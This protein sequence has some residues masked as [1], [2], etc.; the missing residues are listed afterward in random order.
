MKSSSFFSVFKLL[1]ASAFF[2]ISAS[3]VSA[4]TSLGKAEQDFLDQYPNAQMISPGVYSINNDGI[5]ETYAF[6]IGGMAHTLSKLEDL[7]LSN[8]EQ[9]SEEQLDAMEKARAAL[10]DAYYSEI[11]STATSKSGTGGT[12]TN[13]GTIC[14]GSISY[15]LTAT[16][17]FRTFFSVSASATAGFQQFSGSPAISGDALLYTFAKA[18]NS[19]ASIT[20]LEADL[21]TFSP[22]GSNFVSANQSSAIAGVSAQCLEAEAMAYIYIQNCDDFESVS[23]TY[24]LN[25]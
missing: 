17:E 5:E 24:Q 18:F 16:A 9:I 20:T 1:S 15:D 19:S 12:S 2:S 4:D 8:P 23:R 10:E 21:A 3:A 22:N 6:G 7:I 14:N 25:C 13:S 11:A